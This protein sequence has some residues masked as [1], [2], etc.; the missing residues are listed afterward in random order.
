M[1]NSLSRDSSTAEVAELLVSVGSAYDQFAD[2][3]HA[4]GIDGQTVFDIGTDKADIN[5]FLEALEVRNVVQKTVITSRILR[6][7][8]RHASAS[9]RS[10]SP[11]NFSHSASVSPL[12]YVGPN[13]G[14]SP[15][16]TSPPPKRAQK[17]ASAT[18]KTHSLIRTLPSSP[19]TAQSSRRPANTIRAS[20]ST[21]AASPSSP[22]GRVVSTAL[23]T[24]GKTVKSHPS[25]PS[26]NEQRWDAMSAA[27]R[28]GDWATLQSLVQSCRS[29]DELNW[30]NPKFF[31]LTA[32]HVASSESSA[33]AVEVL[34][35]AHRLIDVNKSD[36]NGMTALMWAANNGRE[37]VIPVLLA[38][39]NIDVNVTATRG[40]CTNRTALGLAGSK[41]RIA[42]LLRD[43]GAR[44][45]PHEVE[46]AR[47]EAEISMAAEKIRRAICS[48]EV[49]A[50]KGLL[51]EF[52]GRDEVLSRD[53]EVPQDAIEVRT[54]PPLFYAAM[55]GFANEV[56]LLLATPGI[57]VKARNNF[58]ET[59]IHGA[60]WFGQ[61]E[62]LELLVKQ[63]GIDLN[64]KPSRGDHQGKTALTLAR[65][66]EPKH[67]CLGAVQLLESHESWGE[68]RK[69]LAAKSA[70]ATEAMLKSPASDR[71]RLLSEVTKNV[72]Y[73][74]C[75][76]TEA[77]DVHA[78]RILLEKYSG[79]KVLNAYP[80]MFVP[81][82]GNS[83]SI[84][85]T[86]TPLIYAAMVGCIESTT[87]LLTTPG[88]DVNATNSLGET[89]IHGAAWFGQVEVLK[90]LVKQSGIDLN[91]K[92]SRGEHQGK[93]ALALAILNDQR[94][95]CSEVAQLLRE[96]KALLE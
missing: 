57:E 68:E 95:G 8:G 87:L 60:A 69:V 38:T 93:T 49:D 71:A 32:L 58:G 34:L 54:L 36:V 67:K 11:L 52:S 16:S 84:T 12:L 22:P 79:D 31:M 66:N 24:K 94:K 23:S 27:I 46:K 33:K 42:S 39:S 85:R 50:L 47:I 15:R 72:A 35:A 20:P 78:L 75:H 80:E 81:S 53:P 28:Q 6:S 70:A 17:T 43:A 65:L 13:T 3:V 10:T 41:H 48:R 55:M 61:V 21:P 2:A 7:F 62:V 51:S 56:Q 86:F 64:I 4:Y 73:E 19:P 88:V 5:D 1:G 74:I 91:I 92:P 89:A 29:K 63:S 25:S 82:G 26:K 59:A 40:W 18:N 14:L 45:N 9:K 83:D 77:R 37:E 96:A 30:A 90:L 76:A 44:L